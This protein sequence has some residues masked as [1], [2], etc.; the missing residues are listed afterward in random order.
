MVNLVDVLALKR[1]ED[2]GNSYECCN[3]AQNELIDEISQYE[4]DIIK[5]GN[6]IKSHSTNVLHI[7]FSTH[8]AEK[9]SEHLAS[10]ASKWIVRKQ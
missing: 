5:L 7:D 10:N 1:K 2:N 8:G 3:G 6:L 4:I 9:L